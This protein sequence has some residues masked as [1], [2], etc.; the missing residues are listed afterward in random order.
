MDY[1]EHY[2]VRIALGLALFLLAGISLFTWWQLPLQSAIATTTATAPPSYFASSPPA[3]LGTDTPT[4][5]FTPDCGLAWRVVNSPNPSSYSNRLPG[6]AA[7]SASD[8]WSVGYIVNP[9]E[10]NARV[11]T[12]HWDGAQWNPVPAPNPDADNL[13]HGAAALS[14]NDV[15]AVGYRDNSITPEQTLTEHWDGTQWSTTPSANTSITHTNRLLSVAAVSTDDVWAV[16]YSSVGTNTIGYA[17]TLIEHW[18]G[19]QW[20][21]VPSPN[22]GTRNNELWDVTAVSAN[23]VWAVGYYQLPSGNQLTLILHWDGDQWSVIPSPNTPDHFQN[24]LKGIAASS[25]ND[26]WAVGISNPGS[27]EL[28]LHWDG[29]QWSIIPTPRVGTDG[30][31]LW[32]V[33]ALSANDA[34]AVGVLNHTEGGCTVAGCTLALHW[35]GKN[36]TWVPSPSPGRFYNLL[37]RVAAISTDEVWAVGDLQNCMSCEYTLTERYSDNP[38]TIT[39]P[40]PTP[41]WTPTPTS[42]PCSITFTDVY[43]GDYFYEAVRYLYCIGAISGYAD[44]TFRPYNNTTRAQLCK[45]IVLSE[46]WD[47][48]TTGGPHFSDVPEG[49]D[50]YDYIETAYNHSIITGYSNGT[51]RPDTNVARGQLCKI[52]TLAQG[53]PIDTTGGP[54][55]SDVP[56]GSAFYDYIETAY[57]HSI[58]NGYSDGTFRPGNPAS[59]GQISKIIYQAIVGLGPGSR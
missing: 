54:H 3:G 13:L 22:V 53:W 55:F 46:G 58:I 30:G 12:I 11:L 21:I 40:T 27:L 4:P 33:T 15:W 9:G 5:T 32:G 56:Q 42:T 8:V 57:N 49:S 14:P 37:R 44:N 1:R 2:S 24:Y 17:N 39:S 50:F 51:F 48:D 7:L 23:D 18:D 59:R 47:I 36:W 16:G 28:A 6:L 34:W 45:I 10:I 26:V 35:N 43:S 41:T 38:C 31:D 20:S 52:V 29:A 25:A 19:S